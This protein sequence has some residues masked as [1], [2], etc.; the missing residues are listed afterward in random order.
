MREYD[1]MKLADHADFRTTRKYYLRVHDDLVDRA[2]QA[3][4]RGLCQNLLQNCA[5]VI[6]ALWPE[7]PAEHNCLVANMF[8]MWVKVE[9][10]RAH[11]EV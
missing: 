2:R 3:T 4:A 10:N 8:Q 7:K 11:T 9:L 1:V 6:L 5:A